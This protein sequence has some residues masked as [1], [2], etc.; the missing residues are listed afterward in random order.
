MADLIRHHRHHDPYVG[1]IPVPHGPE[2]GDEHEHY[3]P[4]EKVAANPGVG[5]GNIFAYLT[6]PDDCYTPEGVYWADLPLRKRI[7]FVNKVQNEEAK[8][9]LQS[10]G[11]MMKKD[12][13]SPVSWYFRNAVLPG[14]GLGLEGYVLFSIGNLEPLFAAAWPQCWGKKATECSSNWVAS[15]TYLEVIG[16]MVGQLGIGVIGD[17][18]GRR[19]GLI[20][21]AAIMFVGL[22]MLTASWGLNLNGWVICYAWSLFFYGFGVGGEYPITA[23]TSME[24]AVTAGKLSTREDRLHRGRKVTMAFLMQGWG[25]LINQAVLILLLLIFHHGSGDPPYNATVVQWTFRVSF[26]LPAIGTLW[27]VYYRTYKMPHANRQLAATK[28]KANVTGYDWES[29]KMTGHHFGGRLIAAAGGW[30]CN[31]VFF[32]G[33]KLFQAQFIA[34]ISNHSSSVMVGWVWNLL[35]VIISL[36]GYYCASLLIDNK[37]Y[38]RKMMQQVGFLMCFIMFVVPAFKFEY[39][40]SP[41]GIKAFQAMYFLSSFFNQFGPNSVTFLVAGEIF[42]TPVRASAH[43]FSACIGKAGALLA[44]VLYNYIDTQMKFYVVPWFGLAGMVLT[45]LFLPDTTGLDLKEQERRWSYI[46]AGREQDYHGIAIHPSHLSLWERMR[47]IGKNYDPELDLQQKIE[48][49]RE[50]WAGKERSRRDQE[51]GGDPTGTEDFEDDEFNDAVHNYFRS[52]EPTL[53]GGPQMQGA[54]GAGT[55]TESNSEKG[56]RQPGLSVG[57]VGK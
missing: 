41:A 34:V 27:L 36:I 57:D 23:T 14:A 52:T 45:W 1:Q 6:H 22:L 29:L 12:P 50:E 32:Y 7:T 26:A 31:D 42:P 46:R 40:T 21:D 28:K 43:G 16:I 18:I 56:T 33:N 39:Y 10:I 13:L 19:W 9:E 11:R 44:S 48:D 54:N 37:F 3:P 47:G 24:N 55:S 53:E 15:V 5:E 17:W 25:Q 49:M 8:K 38:G 51:T 30:F 4:R 20:Q 2:T 35:N